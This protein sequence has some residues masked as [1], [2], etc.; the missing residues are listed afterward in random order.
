VLKG[1]IKAL[2]TKKNKKEYMIAHAE[3]NLCFIGRCYTVQVEH[4]FA[5][6]GILPG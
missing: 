6:F 2:E 4:P 3:I 5:M 1:E